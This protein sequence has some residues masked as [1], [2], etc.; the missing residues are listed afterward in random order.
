MKIL[1][2]GDIVGKIGREAMKKIL[3]E[4]TEKNQ[5]DFILANGEN[6]AHAIGFNKKTVKEILN[7]GVDFLTS[8]N[9][10][11]DREDGVEYLKNGDAKILRPANLPESNP[12]RGHVILEKNNLKLLLINLLGQVFMDNMD[13][14]CPFVKADALLK[15]YSDQKYD[16]SLVDFHAEATS[17]KEAMGFY[18]DGRVSGVMGTHTHIA[19]ADEHILPK[20]TAFCADIGM[21]GAEDAILGGEKEPII[22]KFLTQIPLHFEAPKS[23]TVIVNSCLIETDP[24]TKKAIHIKRFDQ[25]VEV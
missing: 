16:A 1:F 19:T 18:L 8:G 12:G 22:K 23:G 21:V 11:F 5:P 7:L 13:P 20:G 25:R 9:H 4:I 2:F 15:K 3:P 6:L 24:K 10:V 14:N 17:E